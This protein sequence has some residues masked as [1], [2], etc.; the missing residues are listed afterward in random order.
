MMIGLIKI[1]FPTFLS[2]CEKIKLMF[3][4]KEDSHETHKAI[5]KL[6]DKDGDGTLSK[7]EFKSLM[8]Q[9]FEVS[10][11]IFWPKILMTHPVKMN[12]NKRFFPR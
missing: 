12:L 1:D 2:L 8:T 9:Y 11:L 7:S 3:L 5:F 6:M 4:M 10:I